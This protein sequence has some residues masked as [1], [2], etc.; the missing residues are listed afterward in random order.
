M[1]DIFAPIMIED[2]L[3]RLTNFLPKARKT[4]FEL[5]DK[6]K[7]TRSKRFLLT[8]LIQ[9]TI[10]H[11]SVGDSKEV[12]CNSLLQTIDA[13]EQGFKWK[14]FKY[15]YGGYDTMIWLLSLGVLCD[16]FTEDFKRITDI[17]QR[18]GA[19][20]TLLSTIIT[21]KQ[22]GWQASNA[23]VI[24]QHPYAK[25]TGLENAQDIKNYLDK[26]WYQGHSDSYWHGLHKNTRVNNYF[27][28]WSWESAALAKIKNI[29]DSSL[30]NQKY[31]PYDA[32]HW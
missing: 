17:L 31:Y 9:K 30:K 13:F 22:P 2:K 24:Q 26:V 23:P 20:D 14:G 19:N 4:I 32:V 29:E 16:I 25:A 5:T 1:R 7:I 11:Y 6:E 28:Y 15:S 8:V 10:A 18:D 21:Y 12:V 3:N 27:G